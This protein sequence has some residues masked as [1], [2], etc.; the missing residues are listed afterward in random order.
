M[1]RIV[2]SGVVGAVVGAAVRVGVIALVMMTG[3]ALRASAGDFTKV[4]PYFVVVTRESSPMRCSDGRTFYAVRALKAGEVLR[5]DGEGSGWLRVEYLPGM[6]AHIKASELTLSADGKSGSL[7]VPSRLMAANVESLR[8]WWP[9]LAQGSELEAGTKFVV[10]EAVKGPDG[11]VDGYLVEAPAGSRGYV[12]PEQVRKAT[13]EESAGYTSIAGPGAAVPKTAPMTQ[14]GT[15]PIT[16]PGSQ[17][18]PAGAPAPVAPP[19]VSPGVT[20]VAPVAPAPS[21]SPIPV[22]SPGATP[23]DGGA[24]VAPLTPAAPAPAPVLAPVDPRKQRVADWDVLRSQWDNVMGKRSDTSELNA[25][26]AEFQRKIASMG[27]TPED[28]RISEALRQRVRALELRRDVIQ[29]VQAS[30][31]GDP[32]ITEREG[33]V[34]QLVLEAEKQGVYAIVGKMLPSN[35]YDGRRGM[36]LMYRIESADSSST[37]TVGYVIPEEGVDLITKLGKV[38]GIQGESRFDEGLRSQMVRAR[39]VTVLTPTSVI[40]LQNIPPAQ[41]ASQPNNS[42]PPV[43]TPPVQTPPEQPIDL[44]PA[45]PAPGST[46]PSSPPPSPPGQEHGQ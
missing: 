26:I 14:P 15:P 23:P 11:V 32:S 17:P 39:R 13:P 46:P 33:R 29:S 22:E 36:P 3:P 38:V 9:L 37:R 34:R 28:L 35:V 5:V 31:A 24:P 30:K 2:C 20:P 42:L 12:Q 10:V 4:E 41:P 7:K 19:A 8:P 27:S 43:Q 18:T 6:R 40:E 25:V 45:D 21:G 16:P 1:R 44:P